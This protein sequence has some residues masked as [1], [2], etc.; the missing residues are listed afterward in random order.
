MVALTCLIV[1][2]YVHYLYCFAAWQ[3]SAA[4]HT[5]NKLRFLWS[6]YGGDGNQHA[7]VPSFVRPES[8]LLLTVGHVTG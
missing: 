1:M 5:A 7:Y 8:V 4:A 2:L 3:G 6:V